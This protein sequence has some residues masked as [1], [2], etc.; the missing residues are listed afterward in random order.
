MRG[1]SLVEIIVVVAIVAV[2]ATIAL[3]AVKYV[4]AAGR[5]AKRMDIMHNMQFSQELYKI[6]NS[7][8]FDTTNNFCSLL[9]VLVTG[10]Y[11]AFIPVDP[12]TQS[13]ICASPTDGNPL[14]RHSRYFYEA[15]PS[16]GTYL[17]KL[18]KENG[19]SADFYSPQ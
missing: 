19:G 18:G 1:F 16:S 4:L 7:K 10:N 8:Y 14:I 17:L 13:P 2:L 6:R 5:D 11:L 12:L 3:N 15:T 9:D